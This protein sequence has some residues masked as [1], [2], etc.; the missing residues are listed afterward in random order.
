MKRR[1]WVPVLSLGILG[2]GVLLVDCGPKPKTRTG[3]FLDINP[4]S[5]EQV[6]KDGIRI[7]VKPITL[8]NYSSFP[9]I[10]THLAAE[11]PAGPTTTPWVD[12]NVPAFELTI[13]NNTGHVLKCSR[14]V[15]KLQDDRGIIYQPSTK[16]DLEARVD[17]HAQ[18]LAE[19]QVRIDIAAAKG[20]IKALKMADQDLELLPAITEKVY[21][22]FNYPEEPTTFLTG[23][24]YLKLVLFEI[25]VATNDAGEV[26]KTTNF[27]FMYDIHARTVGATR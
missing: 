23:R 26:T 4:N 17:A 22:T 16:T 24:R 21:A 20:R 8:E 5:L 11:A 14:A 25:P 27:E 3:L 2:L 9:G 1:M 12:V 15:I 10:L 18:K 19:D 7:S 6:D 13:L